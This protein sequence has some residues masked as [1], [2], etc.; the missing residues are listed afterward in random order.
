MLN[1]FTM[2]TRSNK[3]LPEINFDEASEEWRKN[4]ISKGNG[5]YRY[6]CGEICK[7]GKPCLRNPINNPLLH[8]CLCSLHVIK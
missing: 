8:E 6:I 7:S 1:T 4:K 3:L 2:K 5:M